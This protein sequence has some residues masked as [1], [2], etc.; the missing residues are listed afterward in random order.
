MSTT[1][2]QD[3]IAE[4][5]QLLRSSRQPVANALAISDEF[6]MEGQW[7][8]LIVAPAAKGISALDYVD[9]I[10]AVE[11]SLRRKFGDE[12]LIVPAKP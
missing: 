4:A 2:P 1:T 11:N 10:A 12:I 3:I 8:H 7:L 9:A 6:L 5:R